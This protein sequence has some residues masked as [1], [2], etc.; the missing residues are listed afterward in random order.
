MHS[1]FEL[2]SNLIINF[3]LE[4]SSLLAA[5]KMHSG[6]SSSHETLLWQF[7]AHYYL[8]DC[9]HTQIY[10]IRERHGRPAIIEASDFPLGAQDSLKAELADILRGYERT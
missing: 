5:N 10:P 4:C 6:L 1:H 8:G 2:V 7:P 9:C 3:H